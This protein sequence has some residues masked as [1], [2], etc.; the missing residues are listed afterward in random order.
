MNWKLPRRK[1]TILLDRIVEEIRSTID[2]A[3]IHSLI[4]WLRLTRE[5]FCYSKASACNV[6]LCDHTIQQV[7]DL[8]CE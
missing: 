5:G 6:V 1:M 7:H 8:L 3:Q 2:R 4:P